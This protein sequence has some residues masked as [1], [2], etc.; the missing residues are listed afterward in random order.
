MTAETRTPRALPELRREDRGLPWIG[1]LFVYQK[2]PVAYY[3]RQWA[4]YGP[5]APSRMLGRTTVMLLGP[6]AC[7]AALQNRD[8][9]FANGPAW[10]ELVG[11]FFRRGLMLLDFDDHHGHRRIMQ[12]AFTPQRLDGYTRRLHPAIA[13]GTAD[14]ETGRRFPAYR[15]LKQLTLDIAADLFMGGARDTG[16]AEMA[17]VNRAFIACVQ[18]A[19]GMLRA[20][21]PFTRWGR[22]Y[23]A[24]RV[25]E[26]F[27]RHYLPAKRATATD[28]I[29]SVLC[30]IETE[31]GDR[32]SDDDVINHMIF[33]MMAAHDTSTITTTAILQYLGQHPDWQERC[34]AEARALGPAPDRAALESLVSLDLVMREALRLRTP[35]PVLV[36]YTVKDTVVEG[37]RIPA[38]TFCSLGLQFTH[39]MEEHWTNPMVFDPERFGPGRREDRSHRFAW[40]PFG[41][42]VHKCIGLHFA[43][44]EVKAIMHRLLRGHHWNVDPGY[45]PPMDQHALPFPKDGQPIVLVRN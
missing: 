36:R 26:G 38:D 8:K 35:V 31:D 1:N 29:F 9:A 19:G 32:F 30:H 14:W 34:R 43:G 33:L 10:S 41:G 37:V 18:A 23:R 16:A 44:L 2:D 42:G 12:E 4:R 13:H 25:L 24:R 11:P 45:V 15:R 40:E 39:L 28:D 7:G 5:V 17:R 6:D 3:R 20:D 22:A 21:V 27:L